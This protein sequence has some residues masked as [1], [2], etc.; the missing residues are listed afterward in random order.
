MGTNMPLQVFLLRS[1]QSVNLWFTQF[2]R[3]AQPSHNELDALEDFLNTFSCAWLF[4]V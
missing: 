4:Q 2:F 3:V 1:S